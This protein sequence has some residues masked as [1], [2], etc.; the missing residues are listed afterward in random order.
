MKIELKELLNKL[1][2]PKFLIVFGLAGILLIGIS[3]FASTDS[4]SGNKSNEN[5]DIESYRSSM[6]KSVK[7]IVRG[8]TG[9]KNATVVVTLQ[10][11][12]KY[13]YADDTKNDTNV[14]D[15]DKTTQSSERK[16]SSHITVKNSAGEEKALVITE[17]MPD[18]RGVA[19][20]CAGG[21]DETVSEQI[22]L[23]V[24]AALNI[25]SKRVYIT[26]KY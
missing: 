11:G 24:M 26:G 1:K 6:E 5:F 2:E 20:V 23:A 22:R 13:S 3:S 21:D 16:E 14:T 7:S 8:V 18:I 25:T 12:I 17:N 4:S 19:I 9:D 15:S 10:N